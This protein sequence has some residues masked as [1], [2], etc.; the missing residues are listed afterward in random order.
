MKINYVQLMKENKKKIQCYNCKKFGYYVNECKEEKQVEKYKICD[1]IR[2]NS[3]EIK[4]VKNVKRKD[5]M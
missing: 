1:K 5:I 2:H 4:L 3:K